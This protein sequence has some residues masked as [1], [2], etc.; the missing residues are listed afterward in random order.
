MK[1]DAFSYHSTRW[2]ALRLERLRMDNYRCVM[3]NAECYGKK[4]GSLSPRVD[5]IKEV[6]SHPELAWDKN[7]LRTLC[8]T[9]D[10]RRHREKGMGVKEQNVEVGIDGFPIGGDW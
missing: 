2:R 9:C 6:K 3:C 4:R 10:N 1:N 5:H 8:P 7:N